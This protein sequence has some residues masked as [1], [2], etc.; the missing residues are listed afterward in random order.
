[1]S[2]PAVEAAQQV[3]ELHWALPGSEGKLTEAAREAL[4]PIQLLSNG[5]QDFY[6]GRDDLFAEGVKHVLRDLAPLIF[7]EEELNARGKK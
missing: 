4:K 5:F 1:M 7:T 3:W 6:K 2:D